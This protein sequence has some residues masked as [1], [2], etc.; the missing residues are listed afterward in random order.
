MIH[1][2]IIALVIVIDINNHQC[3]DDGNMAAYDE[4]WVIEGLLSRRRKLIAGHNDAT[5]LT[6]LACNE[7]LLPFVKAKDVPFIQRLKALTMRS[8][9]VSEQ[10]YAS[11]VANN[12]IEHVIVRD[13][14][15]DFHDRFRSARMAHIHVLIDAYKAVVEE[16]GLGEEPACIGETVAALVAEH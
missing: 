2:G 6:V 5:C 7:G 14:M 13:E 12:D 9:V 15:T 3:C 10:N 8:H 1:R 16:G 4:V 11:H